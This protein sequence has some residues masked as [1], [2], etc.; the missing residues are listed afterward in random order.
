MSVVLSHSFFRGG[1]CQFVSAAGIALARPCCLPP[2]HLHGLLVLCEAMWKTTGIDERKHHM[3]SQGLGFESPSLH[4][5]RERGPR[6]PPLLYGFNE[7][8]YLESTL[9][10][11]KG[12]SDVS[13]I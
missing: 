12:I 5:R 10:T 11:V 4:K 7:I 1:G 8:I 3:Q 2:G 13:Y 9:G 6:L